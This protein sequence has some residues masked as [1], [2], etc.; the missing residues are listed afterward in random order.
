MADVTGHGQVDLIS[1][2]PEAMLSSNGSITRSWSTADIVG[3]R[4]I[5]PHW[6]AVSPCLTPFVMSER[7]GRNEPCHCGS[8]SKYKKCCL[9]K[10]EAARVAE[11]AT[12]AAAA[13]A[14]PAAPEAAMP[15]DARDARV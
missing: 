7:P 5:L 6:T 9:E 2:H 4:N 3:A 14:A 15:P 13:A 1:Q 10:D 11:R 8:G 12:A